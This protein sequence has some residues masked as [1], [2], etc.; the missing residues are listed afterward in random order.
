VYVP[1][2]SAQGVFVKNPAIAVSYAAVCA[3]A[4][5]ISLKRVSNPIVPPCDASYCAMPP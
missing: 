2:T 3:N 5:F 4:F 1:S